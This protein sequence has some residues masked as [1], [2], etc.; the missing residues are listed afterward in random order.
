MV[1]PSPKRLSTRV[2]WAV[3]SVYFGVVLTQFALQFFIEYVQVKNN[4]KEELA[5]LENIFAEP[6]TA[7]LW[8]ST[9]PQVEALAS[10]ITK[11]PIVTGIEIINEDSGLQVTKFVTRKSRLFHRF[12]LFYTFGEN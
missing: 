2:L 12:Q 8:A 3:L 6:L 10:G 9:I 11:L 7:A 5:G 1:I 4:I